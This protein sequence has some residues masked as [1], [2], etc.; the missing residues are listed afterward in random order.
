MRP[1][2]DRTYRPVTG[3]GLM[4]AN[5]SQKEIP[6]VPPGLHELAAGSADPPRLL[7]TLLVAKADQPFFTCVPPHCGHVTA[8]FDVIERTNFSNWLSQSLQVYS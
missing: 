8:T 6:Q 5:G 7:P 4:R 3:L 1:S 2:L